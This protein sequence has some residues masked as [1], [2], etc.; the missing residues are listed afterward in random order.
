MLAVL[1]SGFA[2]AQRFTG[3]DTIPGRYENYY[4]PEWYD[5]CPRYCT[6]SARVCPLYVSYGYGTFLRENYT[7]RR[8]AVKGIAVMVC[9]VHW[10]H[11]IPP[12]DTVR[13]P[14][15]AFLYQWS[16]SQT[17]SLIF[18]DSARWDTVM[19]KVMR[20]KTICDS[21]TQVDP[22]HFPVVYHCYVYECYFKGSHLVDSS[23]YIGTTNNFNDTRVYSEIY[24]W[25][26][27]YLPTTYFALNPWGDP[28]CQKMKYN[29]TYWRL[30]EWMPWHYEPYERES[31]Y[32]QLLAIVDFHNLNVSTNDSTK[33]QAVGSG[34]FPDRSLDTIAAIPNEGCA[35]VRWNDGNT[36]NPRIIDLTRDTTFTA[37]FD[38]GA[39]NVQVLANDDEWGT[40]GGSGWYVRNSTV[41]ISATPNER[42]LFDRWSDGEWQNPRT[43][44]L[45]QDTVFTALFVPDPSQIGVDRPSGADLSQGIILSPNPASG[46]LTVTFNRAGE[47]TIEILDLRG[48]TMTRSTV[49]G[50]STTM[51][52]SALPAATYLVRI[53][54]G[55]GTAFKKLVVK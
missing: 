6:D 3:L 1:W 49:D 30:A 46:E 31:V 50:I 22:S 39:C 34:R 45:T 17:D 12:A 23:F 35:F 38:T 43:F 48:V 14:Q 29:K 37:Y 27:Q 33:G 36:D 54:T 47:Y 7:P 24:G 32:G 15:H 21:A 53:S 2:A 40:T 16:D 20:L 11:S 51:D 52:I 44:T 41:T 42:Y 13:A 9:Q 55:H 8:M 19:P 10:E 4:Y 28:E 25:Q 18:I 26:H 5:E